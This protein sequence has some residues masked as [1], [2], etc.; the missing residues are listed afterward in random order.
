MEHGLLILMVDVRGRCSGSYGCFSITLPDI[1][2]LKDKKITGSK[3]VTKQTTPVTAV[4]K[5]LYRPIGRFSLSI[6]LPYF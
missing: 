4:M 5:I 3:Y 1:K 2:V 6:H